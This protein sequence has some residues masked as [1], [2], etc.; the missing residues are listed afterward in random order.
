MSNMILLIVAVIALLTISS[1]TA[2][3]V[4][5]HDNNNK[6]SSLRGQSQRKLQH[7]NHFK[8]SACNSDISTATCTPIQT[9]LNTTQTLPT[10]DEVKIPCGVCVTMDIT[11]NS[12]LHFPHG[13]N[14]VGKLHIPQDSS[15]ELYTKYL[16]VQG[17]LVMDSPSQGQ[18]TIPRADGAKVKVIL[19]GNENVNFIP[20]EDGDNSMM[21]QTSIGI[22]PFAVAGGKLDINAIDDD[23]PSWTILKSLSE[24]KME[25]TLKDPSAAECWT[26]GAELLFTPD[27]LHPLQTQGT[28]GINSSH[29]IIRIDSSLLILLLFLYEP[30]WLQLQPLMQH[31]VLLHLHHRYTQG[32]HLLKMTLVN[33]L[34]LRL[35]CSQD[36]SP[37]NQKRI[38]I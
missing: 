1:T 23:C 19:E 10:D 34:L 25:I 14:I 22:K 29:L 30:Q 20:D 32:Q 21:G 7:T 9:F 2:V 4:V 18:T 12:I 15:F 17:H 37:L 27:T 31:V 5:E 36:V 3:D 11:D 13:L 26:T 16:L 6:P 24:N 28:C 8:E 38:Q 35:P 33:T